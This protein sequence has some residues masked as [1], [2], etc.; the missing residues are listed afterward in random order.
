MILISGAN[1][2]PRYFEEKSFKNFEKRILKIF[3]PILTPN[4]NGEF[5]FRPAGA[6][7]IKLFLRP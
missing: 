3:H 5:P 6:N 1:I 4:P 7:L 2:R